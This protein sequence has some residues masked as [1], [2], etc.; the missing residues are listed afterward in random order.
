[1]NHYELESDFIIYQYVNHFKERRFT[2]GV[3]I[4]SDVI[5]RMPDGVDYSIL[6]TDEEF[7]TIKIREYYLSLYLGFWQLHIGF[8]K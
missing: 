6:N 7:E 5:E 4:V 2:L 8:R 3:N 1:M